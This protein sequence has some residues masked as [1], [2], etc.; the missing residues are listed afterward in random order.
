M[1]FSGRFEHEALQLAWAETARR[2]PLLA[3]VVR[4]GRGGRLCW[5]TVPGGPAPIEWRRGPLAGDWPAAWAPLDLTREPGVRG[6]IVET[7]GG[8]DIYVQTH[9]AVMDGAAL[10]QVFHDLMLLYSHALGGHVLLPGLRPRLLAGRGRLAASWWG[11]LQLVPAHLL[12]LALAWP[13]LRREV[14]PL[15]PHHPAA[16]EASPPPGLPAIA[17]RRFSPEE[18]KTIRAAA[19]RLG[20]GLNELLMRDVFAALGVW[21]TEQGVGTPLDWIRLG[22]PVSLRG[23]ADHGLPAAN[24]FSLVGIDRRGK[25]LANRERLLR[26]AGED[27]ALVKKHHLGHTFLVLLGLHRLL[28]GGIRRYTR[29][30]GCRATLV[31]TNLGPLVPLRSGL[32]DADQR[33]AVPGAVIEEVRIGGLFRP[34]TCAT[35]AFA[36]YAGRLQADFHHDARFLTAAQAESFMRALESQIRLSM[37]AATAAA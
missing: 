17:G 29:R 19:K 27:M 24:V 23:P 34:G 12:G 22:L 18:T 32:L 15:V 14:A 2:H 31:M 6:L 21:R 37:D 36:L 11:R 1:R 10:F 16:P 3:G 28:P 20:T 8:G 30:E 5:A 35:L 33:L 26:R 7:D 4:P 13:I 9:H 25:S